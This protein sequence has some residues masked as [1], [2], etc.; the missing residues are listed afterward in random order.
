MPRAKRD[1][2]ARLRVVRCWECGLRCR[3]QKGMYTLQAV[4]RC[5]FHVWR[6]W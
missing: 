6:P 4:E 3:R 5:R 2:Y 1:A